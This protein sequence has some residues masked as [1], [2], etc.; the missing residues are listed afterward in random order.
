VS[1]KNLNAS[2]HGLFSSFH[3]LVLLTINFITLLF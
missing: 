3:S 1:T 2:S